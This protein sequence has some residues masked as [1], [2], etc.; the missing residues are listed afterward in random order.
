VSSPAPSLRPRSRHRQHRSVNAEWRGGVLGSPSLPPRSRHRQHRP[1]NALVLVGRP[2][3]LG[4]RQRLIAGRCTDGFLACTC[5]KKARGTAPPE[6]IEFPWG[7][8]RADHLQP[9]YRAVVLL[10]L[11]GLSWQVIRLTLDVGLLRRRV[12]LSRVLA[13]GRAKS[14]ILRC[15]GAPGGTHDCATMMNGSFKSIEVF[16][17]N[18]RARQGREVIRF[19]LDGE[20]EVVS[21]CYPDFPQ[22]REAVTGPSTWS[23]RGHARGSPAGE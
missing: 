7:P 15:M 14:D 17:C 5:P 23:Y 9:W 11:L 12:E 13:P 2:A 16:R 19:G 21:I 20:D 6:R 22:D 4:W 3:A 1:S 10:I 18:P 8:A